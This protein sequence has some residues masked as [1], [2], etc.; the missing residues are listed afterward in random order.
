MPD[1]RISQVR[2][3]ALVPPSHAAFWLSAAGLCSDYWQLLKAFRNGR[4]LRHRRR[5]WKAPSFTIFD[6]V[7]PNY[8]KP[9]LNQLDMPARW[10]N[11]RKT[12][13]HGTKIDAA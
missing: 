3:E 10:E 8:E 2:F 6:G 5:P 7:H 9:L 12:P 11:F 1:G 13:Q 4:S